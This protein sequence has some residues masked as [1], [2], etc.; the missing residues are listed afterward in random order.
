MPKPG[1][2][3]PCP[4]GSGKKFKKCCLERNV[5]GSGGEDN[6]PDIDQIKKR[7]DSFLRRNSQQLEK[8]FKNAPIHPIPDE[9]N[10]IEFSILR[11]FLVEWVIFDYRPP[12]EKTLF[13][14]FVAAKGK[15]LPNEV[16]NWT[17]CYTTFFRVE[18]LGQKGVFLEKV[19]SEG[20]IFL[21]IDDPS[22]VL[23][24]GDIVIFRPLPL[25][26]N[27]N[28]FF[29]LYP[30]PEDA[31]GHFKFIMQDYYNR[32]YPLEHQGKNWEEFFQQVPSFLLEVFAALALRD[33]FA[34]EEEDYEEEISEDEKNIHWFPRN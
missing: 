15:E 32:F 13:E 10:N 1:R 27:F 5:F 8:G 11:A 2:N 22:E 19:F 21:E 18:G 33:E 28:Y 17:D 6:A 7:F 31:L 12:G 3:E 29:A 25:G 24:E 9:E 26:K 4:C 20:S 14:K 23:G 34:G 30:I 16:A